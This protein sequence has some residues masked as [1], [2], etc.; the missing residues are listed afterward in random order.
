MALLVV[1]AV[2]RAWLWMVQR[3][4]VGRRDQCTTTTRQ[5]SW[6]TPTTK[7]LALSSLHGAYLGTM[8]PH[9]LGIVPLVHIAIRRCFRVARCVGHPPWLPRMLKPLPQAATVPELEQAMLMTVTNSAMWWFRRLCEHLE[10][11]VLRNR[12]LQ[13]LQ[14]VMMHQRQ[15]R[16]LLQKQLPWV[17]LHPSPPRM[18]WPRH[19]LLLLLLHPRLTP[20]LPASRVWCHPR[21]PER[22]SQQSRW[23]K[24]VRKMP[25]SKKIE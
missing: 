23:S 11:L 17:R 20:S 19:C 3:V 5:S 6:L 8:S 4:P 24:H 7:D 18:H 2:V 16:R 9:R 10:L 1:R 21:F 14:T 12:L 22:D 25:I 13:V 15:P